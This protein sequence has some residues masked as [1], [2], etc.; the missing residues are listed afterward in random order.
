MRWGALNPTAD[1]DGTVGAH[2]RLMAALR[3]RQLGTGAIMPRFS[4]ALTAR[5]PCGRS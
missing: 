5:G 3:I 2:Q 4:S 1:R